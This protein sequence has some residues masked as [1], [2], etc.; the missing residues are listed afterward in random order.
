MLAPHGRRSQIK[1]SIVQD[2]HFHL[3]NGE[4]CKKLCSKKDRQIRRPIIYPLVESLRVRLITFYMDIRHADGVFWIN[5]LA[6]LD[7]DTTTVDGKDT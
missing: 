3:Y 4:E 1:Q 2:L 7:D 6:L 5:Q